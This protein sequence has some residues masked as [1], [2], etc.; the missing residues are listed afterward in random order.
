MNFGTRLRTVIAIIAVINQALVTIGPVDFGNEVS[1]QI[2]KWVS[3]IFLVLAVASSHWYNNDF[4]P[5]AA[6][7]TGEMRAEKARLKGEEPAAIPLV[8]VDDMP[9][10][11][12]A[13]AKM[14]PAE[15]PNKGVSRD[16]AC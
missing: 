6:E 7:K 9:A 16:F 3:L 2:Y 15:F 13:K 14:I 12:N 1:N 5:I 8:M 11:S 4:T 10:M